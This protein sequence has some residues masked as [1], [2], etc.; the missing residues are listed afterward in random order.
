MQFGLVSTDLTYHQC[1]L[2]GRIIMEDERFG[3][4]YLVKKRHRLVYKNLLQGL[5]D[6]FTF[7]RLEMCSLLTVL[8][9]FELLDSEDGPERLKLH[10]SHC[11]IALTCEPLSPTCLFVS[12]IHCYG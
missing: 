5:G 4:C 12:S 2:L 9:Y 11:V 3:Y 7:S 10:K 6:S 1:H 8:C